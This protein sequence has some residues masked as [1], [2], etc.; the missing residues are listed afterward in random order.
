M[1]HTPSR[2]TGRPTLAQVAARAG[3]SQITASRALRS[4]ATVDPQ[5]AIRV[6]DAAK[7]LAYV[8]NPAART[9]ASARSHSILVLVPALSNHLFIETLEAVQDV[10]RPRGFEVLIGNYHYRQDEE[11]EL[12]RNY[13]SFQPCGILLTGFNRSETAAQL[14]TNA[15]VPC[16][17][18]MELRE[19]EGIVC[20]GFSQEAAGAKVADHL[21]SR[22]R[23]KLVFVGAQLDARVLQRRDG[24]QQAI[25]R[26]G[27]SPAI[28]IM[29]PEPSSVELGGDLFNQLLAAH[30]DTDGIF[31]CNDDLAFGAS[32]EALRKGVAIPE[33]ISVVGFNDLPG[34][35]QM[36][37]RLT[38][39]RTPRATIGQQAAASLLKLLD[40]ETPEIPAL[41]LGF[42]LMIRESS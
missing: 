34:A 33:R 9:L 25:A 39:V 1:K 31:F 23:R 29:T 15:G 20:V 28:E 24:Y 42:E 10:L 40:G 12:I 14:L 16:V 21:L 2:A 22:G 6:H 26:A 19:E 11:E 41:D 3:V 35:G 30:P 5:L 32:F 13:L 37:P 36:V 8:P 4:I 18:M 17:Y 7:A 27:L 38:S